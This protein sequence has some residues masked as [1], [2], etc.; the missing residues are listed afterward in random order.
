[1]KKGREKEGEDVKDGREGEERR[2]RGRGKDVWMEGVRE[3]GTDVLME[4][5]K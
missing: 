5:E 2:E 4:G 3:G 1:M